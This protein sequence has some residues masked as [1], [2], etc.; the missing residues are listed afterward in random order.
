MVD[1]QTLRRGGGVFGLSVG[2]VG[3]GKHQITSCRKSGDVVYLSKWFLPSKATLQ[4]TGNFLYFVHVSTWVLQKCHVPAPTAAPMVQPRVAPGFTSGGRDSPHGG[5]RTHHRQAKTPFA[6]ST[7]PLL[8]AYCVR[9]CSF[10][11]KNPIYIH[12]RSS[13]ASASM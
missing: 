5:P 8:V 11:C 3:S 10:G 9:I 7:R 6:A 13:P 2:R 4:P 1:H 12:W